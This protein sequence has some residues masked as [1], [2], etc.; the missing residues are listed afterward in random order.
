VSTTGPSGRLG[1]KVAL[2]TGGA[3]GLGQAVVRRF[4]DEGASVAIADIDVEAAAALAEELG[5]AARA[6]VL[7][8]SSEPQWEAAV[9]D[10]VAAFG[11]LHVGV[12]NAGIVAHNSLLDTTLE[13]YERVV[14]VNQVGCFLGM[15]T[16][17]LVMADAGGGAMVNISSVRGLTGATSLLSYSATKFAVRGMTKVAAL[18]LGPLGI[19][20]NSVHPGPVATRLAGDAASDPEAEARAAAIYF[21]SQPLARMAQPDEVAALVLFLA[22][23]ES[24]YCTGAEFVVDGGATAGVRRP[25][26]VS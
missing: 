5:G 15:R 4:V 1:G 12:N 6:V 17:A 21:A 11:A 18:E 2:V 14:R 13:E 25:G 19:R 9:A 20:V 26:R 8:V 23:D 7:D 3:H 24:S 10:T 16:M 22:S